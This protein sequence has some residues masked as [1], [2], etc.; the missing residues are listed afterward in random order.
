MPRLQ[1]PTASLLETSLNNIPPV[2][3]CPPPPAKSPPSPPP[4]YWDSVKHYSST[5]VMP[6]MLVSSVRRNESFGM[7]RGKVG[8]V[9]S[10]RIQALNSQK[11]DEPHPMQI[12]TNV[13]QDDERPQ[14]PSDELSAVMGTI[15]RLIEECTTPQKLRPH[16]SQLK[17]LLPPN[18]DPSPLLTWYASIVLSYGID[19]PVTSVEEVAA[20]AIKSIRG[21]VKRLVYGE[22]VRCSVL[23]RLASTWEDS[24]LLE[25]VVKDRSVKTVAGRAIFVVAYGR[26]KGMSEGGVK[27]LVENMGGGNLIKEAIAGVLRGEL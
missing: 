27:A 22:P 3:K 20:G 12:E 24:Q 26:A 4:A 16:I 21:S 19:S 14:Q 17:S 5:S 11:Q 13:G 23:G 7:I 9:H 15:L 18:P 6:P 25:D 2:P 1:A 10:N 8:C